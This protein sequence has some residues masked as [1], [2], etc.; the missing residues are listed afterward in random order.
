[1][2][3]DIQLGGSQKTPGTGR[4][5]SQPLFSHANMAA[6]EL[7]RPLQPSLLR[8]GPGAAAALLRRLKQQTNL[9]P[10]FIPVFCLLYT[11]RCV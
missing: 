3:K 10:D 8:Q 6:V 1:M 7:V 9:S 5:V 11:S 4:D 2:K